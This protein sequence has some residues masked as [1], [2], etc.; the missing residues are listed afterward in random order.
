MYPLV[1]S[2]VVAGLPMTSLSRD[3]P[4]AAIWNKADSGQVD[5]D[6]LMRPSHVVYSV[7]PSYEVKVC[8]RYLELLHV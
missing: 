6:V 5:E 7:V 3:T 1:A 2:V 4:L 8:L